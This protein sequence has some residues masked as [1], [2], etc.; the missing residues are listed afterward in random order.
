MYE[1]YLADPGS[2]SDAWRDFFADYRRDID[3]VEPPT[4]TAVPTTAPAPPAAAPA[5][6]PATNGNATKAAPATAAAKDGKKAAE[7][8]AKAEEPPGKPLR[9]VAAKIVENM[10]ASLQVPTATSFRNVPARLLE[11]NRRVINGYLGRTRG[12]KVSF[13]QLIGYAVVRAIATGADAMARTYVEGPDGK[14]R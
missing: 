5:A 12:G 7:P 8:D 6:A 13:T 4:A 11:V 9:G 2:V 14:P 3:P 1:Q 10:E